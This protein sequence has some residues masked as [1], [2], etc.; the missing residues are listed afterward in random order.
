[1]K[2]ILEYELSHVKTGPG[3]TLVSK[4]IWSVDSITVFDRIEKM[5]RIW[6]DEVRYMKAII[7]GFH[8][9]EDL[10]MFATGF[11]NGV[12]ASFMPKHITDDQPITESV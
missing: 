1:M 11:M 2:F 3:E 5:I 6:K 4:R 10:D 12:N 7:V 9:D 8:P